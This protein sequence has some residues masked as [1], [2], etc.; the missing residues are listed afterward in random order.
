MKFALFSKDGSERVG[1]VRGDSVLDVTSFIESGS[2]K[3][4]GLRVPDIGSLIARF[5]DIEPIIA[6]IE[7]SDWAAYRHWVSPLSSVVLRA[8]APRLAKNIFCVGRNY[9]EHVA[10]G[11]L[12]QGRAFEK[13]A[14]PQFFTKPPTTIIGPDDV[15]PRHE[16]VTG[17][18]DYEV[19][20]AVIIGKTGTNISRRDAAAHIFGY[21]VLNDVTARDLQRRHQQWFKGKG[22]DGSCPIGPWIVHRSSWSHDEPHGIRLSVNGELRQDSQVTRMI[23]PVDELIEILSAG[24]TLQAGDIIATGTPSGVGYARTPP[25]FLA[26]GDV[27]AAEIDGI[28]LLRNTVGAGSAR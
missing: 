9:I 13:P 11:D 23:W 15:I 7:T 2:G 4:S 5:E 14:A 25:L 27:V 3:A 26:S 12:A 16:G 24:L 17:Q 21:S 19:E 10:E 6:P 8:P 28:G 20:L 1:L 18:L 22:L